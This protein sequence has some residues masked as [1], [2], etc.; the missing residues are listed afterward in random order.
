MNWPSDRANHDFRPSL[1]LEYTHGRKK[2]NQW[3]S[4]SI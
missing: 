1:L 3:F 2:T 4:A